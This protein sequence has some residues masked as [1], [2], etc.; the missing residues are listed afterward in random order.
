MDRCNRYGEK[1]F[2]AGGREWQDTNCLRARSVRLYVGWKMTPLI[3][4]VV[5][6][7]ISFDGTATEQLLGRPYKQFEEQVKDFVSW[8]LTLPE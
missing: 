3:T 8:F 2:S 1:A 5:T 4:L 6:T 7:V